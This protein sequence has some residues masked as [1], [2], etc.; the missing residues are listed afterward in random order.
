[1]V[2]EFHI[3]TATSWLNLPGSDLTI[4]QSGEFSL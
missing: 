1:M 3:E 4:N 2:I